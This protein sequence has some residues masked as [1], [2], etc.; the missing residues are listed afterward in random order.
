MFDPEEV[1]SVV[2]LKQS[3]GHWWTSDM[4]LDD[5]DRIEMADVKDFDQLLK[6]Y[7]EVVERFKEIKWMYDDLCK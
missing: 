6:L 5:G 3:A 1:E 7:D 2:W 4:S